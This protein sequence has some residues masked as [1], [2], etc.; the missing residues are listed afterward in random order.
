MTRYRATRVPKSIAICCACK[1]SQTAGYT[2]RCVASHGLFLPNEVAIR[3]EQHRSDPSR[4]ACLP[5]KRDGIR[6]DRVCSFEWREED[7]VEVRVGEWERGGRDRSATVLEHPFAVDRRWG[8]PMGRPSRH[9]LI[10][11]CATTC[12]SQPRAENALHRRGG[13]QDASLRDRF[14][15]NRIVIASNPGL[16]AS[17]RRQRRLLDG[18]SAR[19][20]SVGAT[21]VRDRAAR[22]HPHPRRR[23]QRLPR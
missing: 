10:S 20:G 3:V 6:Q 7:W 5:R 14:P 11:V 17:C 15:S 18:D 22:L 2:L 12:K 1:Q 4:F 19:Q 21:R 23:H 8:R 16:V 9:R 13:R